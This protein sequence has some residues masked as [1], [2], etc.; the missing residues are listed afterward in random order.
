MSMYDPLMC[1]QAG[2]QDTQQIK[3]SL[4]SLGTEDTT[5]ISKAFKGGGH[6]N[7]SSFMVTAA[8]FESWLVRSGDSGVCG[9]CGQVIGQQGA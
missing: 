1:A 8:T 3:C 6:L 5:T 7:A 2:M 9:E 4:R